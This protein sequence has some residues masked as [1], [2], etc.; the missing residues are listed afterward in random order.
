M[1][2]KMKGEEEEEGEGET[3]KVWMPKSVKN[4]DMKTSF[5][6]SS[7]LLATSSLSYFF[8]SQSRKMSELKFEVASSEREREKVKRA[9]SHKGMPTKKEASAAAASLTSTRT[10]DK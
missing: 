10:H 4:L 1:N 5:S 2:K 7:P 3:V 9:S 8:C 6:S